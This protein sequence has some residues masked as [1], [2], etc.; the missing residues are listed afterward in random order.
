M[1]AAEALGCQ[2]YLDKVRQA[3]ER[4]LSLAVVARKNR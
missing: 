1:P 2:A 3:F 4:M